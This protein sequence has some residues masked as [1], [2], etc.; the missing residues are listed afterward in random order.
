MQ[1]AALNLCK[2]ALISGAE[3]GFVKNGG[4]E[5]NYRLVLGTGWK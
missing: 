3:D 5:I 4:R 1:K 2:S